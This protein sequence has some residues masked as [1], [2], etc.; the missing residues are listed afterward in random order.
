MPDYLGRIAIPT[1]V[2]SGITFPLTADFG[3]GTA[4]PFPI[5]E[6]HFGELSSKVTQVFQIGTGPRRFNFR[7]QRLGYRDR[8]ALFAFFEQVQGSFQTFIYPA[9]Q[10]D[11]TFV[12]YEVIFDTQALTIAELVNGCQTGLTLVECPTTHP[13]YPI[14]TTCFRFPSDALKAALLSQVQQI[15]PLVHIK[16]REPGVNDIYISDQ[17]AFVGVNGYIPRLLGV[18][19][20]GT[21]VIMSQNINGQA[22]NVQFTFGNAD[23]A[24]TMLSN[25]TDLV[26]ATIDLS[27]YHVNTSTLL[28][29]WKGFIIPGGFASDGSAQ[30]TVQASDGLYQIT[31]QYPSRVISR[32]CWKQFND[33]VNCPYGAHGSGGD[34][35]SCDYTFSGVFDPSKGTHSDG[36]YKAPGGCQA[37]G[38]SP[39]L[40]GRTLP[41]KPGYF[42]GHPA[43]P[44]GVFLKDNTS[45]FLGFQRNRV[46]ATSIIS[47]TI[48]GTGLPD[49]WC[50]DYGNPVNAFIARGLIIDVRDEGDYYDV[51]G[52]IGSG[53]IGAY[54]QM[55]LLTNSNGYTFVQAPMADSF[56]PQGFKVHT[57]LTLKS[58]ADL[59]IRQ[60]PGADPAI[61]YTDLFGFQQSPSFSLGQGKP[62]VWAANT[63]AG[64]AFVELRYPKPS[65]FDPTL[66]DGHTLTV[67]ISRGLTGWIFDSSGNRAAQGGCTNPFWVAINTYL[68]ALGLGNADTATQLA[69]FVIPVNGDGSGPAEIA[70]LTV[71]SLLGSGDD[72][73]GHDVP[74]FEFQGTI[75]QTK[76]FRDQLSEI[77]SC[78]LGYYTWEFG[79]LRLGIRENASATD[80][81]TIGNML[82]QSLRLQPITANFEHLRT[83]FADRN[84]Q[85]QSNT[86]EYAD[87]SHA[88]YYGRAGAPLMGP[89]NSLGL[90]KMSQGLRLN[91]TRVREEVGG[92]NQLEWKSARV[93]TFRSTILALS[94]EVGRVVSITHPDIPG[95]VGNFRIQSLRLNRDYS[96]DITAKTVTVSMYDLAFGPKPA[97][98]VPSKLPVLLYPVPVGMQWA[99][100]SYQAD[101]S[102]ALFPGEW[103]FTL[104]QSYQTLADST[105][106]AS[107]TATGAFPVDTFIPNCGAPVITEGAIAKSSTGGFINPGTNG[108]TLRVS[109][110]AAMPDSHGNLLMSPPSPIVLVKIQGTGA[111]PPGTTTNQF[112]ISGVVWPQ[113]PGLTKYV[114]FASDVDDLICAQFTGD[115]T[116]SAPAYGPSSITLSGLGNAAPLARSTWGLPDSGLNKVRLKQKPVIHAGVEG[117]RVDS[118]AGNVITASEC[119]D[120]TGADNFT[121]RPFILLGRNNDAAPMA[122]Y[123][124]TAFDPLTG[125]TATFTLD[126]PATDVMVGDAFAVGF[127][128]YDN[129]AAVAAGNYTITD[130]GLLNA[131]SPVPS[132]GAFAGLTHQGLVEADS[133]IVD[134]SGYIL[135]IWKGLQRGATANIVS[136][137]ADSWTL[138][139]PII[140]APGD[141]WFIV[142]QAWAPYVDSPV[143]TSSTIAMLPISVSMDTS[144]V[145]GE[146]ILVAG[147]VVDDQD[148]ESIEYDAPMRPLYVFGDVGGLGGLSGVN[149]NGLAVNY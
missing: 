100:Y 14:S 24:M 65:G 120:A 10:A 68:R 104:G 31:Q 147:F 54:T 16:V 136:N 7:R 115:L 58:S 86:A 95:G 129:S 60:V 62:Q 50:N 56:P 108:V 134:E 48:W 142:G 111:T 44:Q 15:I 135:Y 37:H 123:N 84:Y 127:L 39:V 19:E 87:K 61:A 49:I 76:P 3:Y 73:S 92:V 18:G 69:T 145:L 21:G 144:N 5:I 67:P 99:P 131:Q 141:V 32:S 139:A 33:G 64:T 53:P 41:E 117:A 27:L 45:G 29:L 23:R 70:D 88:A 106:L 22:D 98:V 91:A 28:Q 114:I 40:N 112:T 140:L 93:A 78:T 90:C 6:H 101:A 113:L 9:P 81:F 124:I 128:G 80:A 36:T 55:Q 94:T 132:T 125:G 143:S 126:R 118:V 43:E 83:T 149:Y 35:L 66:A 46:T 146:T 4:R 59:G 38:M 13:F 75:A 17:R 96:I 26:G 133:T 57:N 77:L 71:P 121:G 63:A 1:P 72:G 116:G 42:G 102:D 82:F 130:A 107:V 109:V 30:F 110:C 20:P 79:K 47:D 12:N 89:A 122:A 148:N 103:T 97:D 52:I 105:S 51:M 119:Y 8:A 74:Q 2:A 85:F 34:P 138:D 137:T 25:D 11:K